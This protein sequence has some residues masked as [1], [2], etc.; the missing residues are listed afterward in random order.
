MLR[1]VRDVIAWDH[2]STQSKT[3]RPGVLEDDAEAGELPT[4]RR[5]DDLH[6]RMQ[7]LIPK[8]GKATDPALGGWHLR[9]LSF[10][11]GQ[12]SNHRLG[13]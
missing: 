12:D 7:G 11:V 2:N 13:L 1:W 10:A 9:G 5:T 3:R 4:S 6:V 8:R